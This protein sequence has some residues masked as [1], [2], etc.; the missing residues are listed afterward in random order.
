MANALMRWPAKQRRL[1]AR[2][3]LSIEHV[4]TSLKRELPGANPGI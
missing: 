2:A 1:I 3:G 4:S